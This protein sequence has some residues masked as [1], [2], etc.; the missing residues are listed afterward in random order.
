MIIYTNTKSRKK[1]AT[2]KR[3][4][5]QYQKW[6][7]DIQS[8]STNFSSGKHRNAPNERRYQTPSIPLDRDSRMYT[9]LSSEYY[10]TF[11]KNVPQYTGDKMIGIGTLHKSNAIPIFNTQD[12]KDQANMRR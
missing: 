2:L 6:L 5:E 10:D 7:K 12:A 8:I 11:K 9:S 1:K 3:K 4:A